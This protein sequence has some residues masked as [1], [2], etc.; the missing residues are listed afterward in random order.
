MN[1]EI[2]RLF[3]VFSLLFAALVAIGSYWLWR[4]PS[5]EARQG[6]PTQLIREVTTKRGLIYAAD[7]KTILARN[8]GREVS[9]RR[10]FL[11]RY[12]TKELT[13]HVVGYA[14]LERARTGLE[15]SMNDF[16]TGGN[17]NLA[18]VLERA[19]ARFGGDVREGNDLVLTID[20]PAQEKALEALAGTCGSIVALE[21][22]S[23]RVLVMASTPSYDPNLAARR[24]DE[25]LAQT[26]PCTPASPLLNR[27]TQGL[28]PPG[29][30]F[31][32]VTAAAALDTGLHTPGSTFFDRGFCIE[33]GQRVFNYSDQNGPEMFGRVTLSESLEHSINAV[34][35]DIGQELGTDTVL[36]YARR[37][38]FYERPPLETP[39]GERLASGLYQ[40]NKLFEPRLESDVDVGRLA[41][42]QERLLAT[43]LQMAVVAA[44]VANGGERM[45]PFVVDR[46]L[47]PDESVL[48]ETEP[49]SLGRATTERTAAE[50]AEMMERVVRTGTGRA[51]QIPG[52]R[53]AGKTGT[54]E[55]GE[56]ELNDAWF[57]GF[58]PAENPKIA[59]AVAISDQ[60]GT[61]GAL[62]AP[63][64]K[65]VMEVL[66][67]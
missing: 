59:I 47:K 25:V 30:T 7:G 32:V 12:P 45:R 40:R 54:A 33:Y 39:E 57:I 64:A 13:S 28:Y 49:K 26:G 10:W 4:A 51:A 65:E 16:L 38:G 66:L 19:R 6:N 8:R 62:A 29:S 18:T 14:T 1:T 27:A 15:E 37:F 61:G 44:T 67:R 22:E 58:A 41:F 20:A 5:L 52:V 55:T 63:K 48:T 31:K 34:F 24:F 53:V 60:E 11:R 9:G 23:G 46:I 50:L 3:L 56:D 42:G 43:P 17:S 36:D 2:R 35:C 21:P